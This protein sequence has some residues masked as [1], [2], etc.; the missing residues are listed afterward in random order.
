MTD[1]DELLHD[2]A[3]RPIEAVVIGASAGGFEALRRLLPPLPANYRLP[4]A[5]VL[6]LP[7]HVE[8]RLAELFARW[9]VR[10]IDARAAAIKSVERGAGQLV[11]ELLGFLQAAKDWFDRFADAIQHARPDDLHPL[12]DMLV[13]DVSS[14]L[15][16]LTAPLAQAETALDRIRSWATAFD[17]AKR[18]G[19]IEGELKKGAQ[20]VLAKLA[21]PGLHTDVA[22]LRQDFAL[23]L[24]KDCRVILNSFGSFAPAH[25]IIRIIKFFG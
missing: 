9:Q 13:G 4:I 23:G 2:A 15:Q 17:P 11:A 25:R 24:K 22:A 19:E 21:L 6:H 20:A 3:R 12:I 14:E 5:V 1:R 8:S 16:A 7:D 10:L 18:V